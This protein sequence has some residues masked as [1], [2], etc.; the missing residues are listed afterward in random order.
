MGTTSKRE[1]TQ[2]VNQMVWT[3]ARRL[4]RFTYASLA[5]EAHVSLD[6]AMM[7]AREWLRSKAIS[8]CDAGGRGGR[9][10]FVV[11]STAE[12]M[13]KPRGGNTC[14]SPEQAMWIAIRRSGAFCATD[15]SALANT[16]EI[17]ISHEQIRAYLQT[18]LAAGYLKVVRKAVHRKSEAV[19]RLLNN[20]GPFAPVSR[21][22][23][24][25]YDP[26]LARVM[27]VP[28]VPK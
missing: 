11:Q 18:L 14:V 1:D 2:A 17:A 25:V 22:L 3:T 19:Y 26:N 15:I 21:R 16:D 10:T 13:P 6:R 27:H 24:V 20:Y 7:L 9:L 12:D 5:A 28:A 8:Q 4:G 23:S